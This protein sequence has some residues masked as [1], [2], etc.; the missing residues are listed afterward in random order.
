MFV[1]V[2]AKP[3]ISGRCK[4]LDNWSLRVAEFVEVV[5]CNAEVFYQGNGA[6]FGRTV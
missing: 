5:R 6:A 4:S 3:T 1:G 2:D